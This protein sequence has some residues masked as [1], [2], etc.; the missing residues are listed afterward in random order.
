MGTQRISHTL[1]FYILSYRSFF[2]LF[3]LHFVQNWHAY[4]VE[5]SK[6]IEDYI[7]EVIIALKRLSNAHFIALM[8]VFLI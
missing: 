2:G 4:A 5:W 1:N 7:F 3:L 8:E 6:I